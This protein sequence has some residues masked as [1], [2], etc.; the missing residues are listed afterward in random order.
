M[1]IQTCE[2]LS[3]LSSYYTDAPSEEETTMVRTYQH[4]KVCLNYHHNY[5][6]VPSEEET[7]MHIHTN[8][9]RRQ[10]GFEGV[11]ANPPFNL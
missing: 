2:G 6:D 5:S 1:H 10:G 11:R 3:Q 4:V 7:T 8:Q 9:A